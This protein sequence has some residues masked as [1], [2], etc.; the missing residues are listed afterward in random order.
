MNLRR[1]AAA[2][3]AAEEDKKL[4]YTMVFQQHYPNATDCDGDYTQAVIHGCELVHGERARSDPHGS[5]TVPDVSR[6]H[7]FSTENALCLGSMAHL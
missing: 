5:P 1:L 2:A 6:Y 4:D 3:A 7:R